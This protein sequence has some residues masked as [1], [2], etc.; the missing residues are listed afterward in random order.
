MTSPK[1]RMVFRLAGALL[2]ASAV[3]GQWW[4]HQR[5]GPRGTAFLAMAAR[6]CPAA[7]VQHRRPTVSDT[8][9]ALDRWGYAR[10]GDLIHRDARDRCG[11]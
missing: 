11:R 3:F 9:V 10:L 7:V 4:Q 1:P 6:H 8:A 2:L 5:V